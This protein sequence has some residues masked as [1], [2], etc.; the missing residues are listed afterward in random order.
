MLNTGTRTA[1]CG[2]LICLLLA[3]GAS[4][5]V[6]QPNTNAEVL[7]SALVGSNP[8][9]IVRSSSLQYC[10]VG[11][12][13]SCGT[14]TNESGTYGIGP[15]IVLSTGDVSRDG[16]GPGADL[17]FAYSTLPEPSTNALLV[18]ITG[19]P[20]HLDCTRLDIVFDLM[21]GYDAI[22]IDAVF[23]SEEYPR[24]QFTGYNDGLGIYVN[25]EN[26]AIVDEQCVNINNPEVVYMDGTGFN[27]VLAPG[28]LPLL[29]FSKYLGDQA[30]SNTLTI[31]IADASDAILDTGAYLSN[32]RAQPVPEPSCVAALSVGLAAMARCV[33]SRRRSAARP[34][35]NAR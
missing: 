26:I 30:Q 22:S 1:F 19:L 20:Y 23:A 21:A 17:S 6:V 29:R 35:R 13:V 25:G 5:I 16:D 11:P 3:T 15:G 14:Y 24:Y 10:S 32:L 8:G 27:G 18:P 9:L 28:G 31:V 4:A 34:R 2:L 7:A 12:I 33:V